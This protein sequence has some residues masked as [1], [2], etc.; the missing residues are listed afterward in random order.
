MYYYKRACALT[1][2]CV[3]TLCTTLH[4]MLGTTS[5]AQT[6]V[7]LLSITGHLASTYVANF[8]IHC[9]C[10]LH[11]HTF[12]AQFDAATKEL[13]ICEYTMSAAGGTA[14]ELLQYSAKSMYALM[15]EKHR[16]SVAV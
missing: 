7:V 4:F 3:G 13:E 6:A 14:Q 2:R 10:L 9:L 11:T 5:H 12:L 16:L 8:L 1:Q 15:N